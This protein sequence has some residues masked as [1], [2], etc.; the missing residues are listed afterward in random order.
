MAASNCRFGSGAAGSTSRSGS[1][2]ERDAQTATTERYWKLKIGAC[3]SCSAGA[4][5]LLPPNGFI[6]MSW[7]YIRQPRPQTDP[8]AVYS[9]RDLAQQPPPLAG[10]LRRSQN[11]LTASCGD[12]WNVWHIRVVHGL[13]GSSRGRSVQLFAY[14]GPPE[15]HV[16]GKCL[17]ATLQCKICVRY[18]C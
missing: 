18:Q 4:P 5:L 14:Y 9:A 12:T 1:R 6:K 3:R 11:P 17:V 16:F 13:W 8:A 7:S 10:R 2:L 15:M